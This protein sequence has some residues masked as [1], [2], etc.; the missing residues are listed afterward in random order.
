MQIFNT[1]RGW[2]GGRYL[3]APVLT[4]HRQAMRFAKAPQTLQF[5]MVGTWPPTAECS[6]EQSQRTLS[7]LALA[8][9]VETRCNILRWSNTGSKLHAE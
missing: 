9:T 5:R 1:Q 8:E 6:R 3:L 2:D 4:A 7:R